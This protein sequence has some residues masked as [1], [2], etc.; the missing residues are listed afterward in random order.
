M[1]SVLDPNTPLFQSWGHARSPGCGSYIL[2][3]T[4]NMRDM[5]FGKEGPDTW[6]EPDLLKH[7]VYATFL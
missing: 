7:L 6:S 5:L 1:A 3:G 4:N 2:V